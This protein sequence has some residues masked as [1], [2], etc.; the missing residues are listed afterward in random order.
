MPYHGLTGFSANEVF[1]T[2]HSNMGTII[3]KILALVM[4][5]YGELYA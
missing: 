1:D 4:G 3:K 5:A 2:Y